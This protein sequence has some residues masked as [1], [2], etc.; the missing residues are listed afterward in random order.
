MDTRRYRD[1]DCAVNNSIRVDCKVCHAVNTVCQVGIMIE[2]FEGVP[3]AGKSYYCVEERIM[4]WLKAGRRVW[5]RMKIINPIKWA[6][7]LGIT[8][9]DVND[10]LRVHDDIS[11]LPDVGLNDAVVIDDCQDFFK[12]GEKLGQSILE[13]F[14]H[15]RHK[16]I[17]AC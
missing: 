2:L 10:L 12:T 6:Q 1:G 7:V 8:E 16:G 17:D 4:P 13:F 14:G 15:H 11:F 3:G 9:Y 5:C